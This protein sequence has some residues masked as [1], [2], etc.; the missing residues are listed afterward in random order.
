MDIK[1]FI[2]ERDNAL[3]S[4]DKAQIE[5]YMIKYGV[6]FP[7]GE[8]TFWRMVHKARTAAINLPMFERA[9]SKAW[10]YARN[11]KSMDDGDVLPP[12]EGKS[13]KQYQQRCKDFGL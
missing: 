3:L 13:F 10:L 5:A 6:P 7:N 8:E 2:K 4:M 11:S 1:Q 12:I 9:A